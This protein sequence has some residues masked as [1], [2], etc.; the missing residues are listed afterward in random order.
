MDKPYSVALQGVEGLPGAERI[1]AEM[2]FIRELERAIGGSDAVSHV[3]RAWLDACEADPTELS[4]ETSSLA[5]KWP[6]AF[7]AAQRA[8]LKNIGE[9]DA[10]FELRLERRSVDIGS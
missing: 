9:S 4:N 1:A 3:Y 7:A 6:K 8:G 10:H 5:V 2:R